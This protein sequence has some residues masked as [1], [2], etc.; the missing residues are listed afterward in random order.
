MKRFAK[1]INGENI[2]RLKAVN[3]FGKTLYLIVKFKL[4]NVYILTFHTLF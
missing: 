3:C 4:F 1:I 2:S